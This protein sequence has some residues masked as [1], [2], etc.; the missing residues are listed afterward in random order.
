MATKGT[1]Q[2]AVD[3]DVEPSSKEEASRVASV[4]PQGT[5]GETPPQGHPSGL[6]VLFGAEAWERF[7]YYGM[8]ALLVLYL[9]NKLG[10]SRDHALEVYGLYTGLVYLT[11]L[12]GGY[13]A[14][15]ILGRRKAVLI[16]GILMALGQVFLMFPATLT[17][18]LGLLIAGNGFFK[19][20]ISTMVGGLYR[21][22]DA[23]RDGAF[24]I[25]YMGI[26]LGALFSPI[27]CG[28]LGERVSWAMGFGS[29]AI[30]MSLGLA[31]FIFGQ[32]YLG[33]TGLPP[34]R[35]N[36]TTKGGAGPYRAHDLPSGTPTTLLTKDYVDVAIWCVGTAAVV[37][38]VLFAWNFVGPV[39]TGLPGWP[40]L[41]LLLAAVS[42]VFFQLYK[43]TS[44]SEKQ[45]VTVIIILVAF[46][47]FFWMGFE[48]AGGT[49]TLFA[50]EQTDRN[51]G[52]VGMMLIAAFVF[53]CA[54]NFRR[55]TKNEISGQALWIGLTGMFVLMG[56]ATVGLGIYD[57]VKATTTNIPASQFQAINPLLI[58]ALAPT[59]SN[60]WS[61]LD[62]G[63]FK[64]STPTKMAIG[65]IL[66]GMGFMVLY[67][68]Q[69]LAIASGTKASAGWLAAVYFVH[70]LGELCLSPIGLSMVTKLAP[71]R[72]TSLAMGLWL[73]SSA[74][75]NYLAGILESL[76]T[77]VHVPIYGFLIVSSIGPAIVLLA[78]TP[79]LKK[80][81]HGKA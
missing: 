62:S 75:A 16:G 31:Q 3:S 49:M 56:I 48:Q 9:V 42:V 65:M 44:T 64:S 7:S 40:K 19:P 54:Y 33:D 57:F 5:D 17:L 41:G 55:S 78:L 2:E 38:G 39:W 76:L 46:N 60:L 4:P 20:N 69:K 58:V 70:T 28:N 47:I 27:I 34:G 29:A 43:G 45:E 77:K 81:M 51:V 66:L 21:E 1:A 80:W 11:P 26:N 8:R 61:K 59:F 35:V 74:V 23:R 68:G 37:Y 13:L 6:Y 32:G 12:L 30:G 14:D 52:G 72:V 53:A 24:T 25:F 73:F 36:E 67:V 22:G 63:K 79:L 18:A 10:Y 71:P 15:K 50:D